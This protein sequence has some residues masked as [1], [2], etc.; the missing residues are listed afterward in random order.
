MHYWTAIAFVILLGYHIP[1]RKLTEHFHLAVT[2]DQLFVPLVIIDSQDRAL[3][4][5]S[6]HKPF[7]FFIRNSVIDEVSVNVVPNRNRVEKVERDETPLILK[8]RDAL[9]FLIGTARLIELTAFAVDKDRI[10]SDLQNGLHH[11]DAGSR[12]V[13]RRRDKPFIGFQ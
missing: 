6:R 5:S 2:V 10:R 7:I 1:A 11:K 3:A 13:M 8:I 4:D 9:N 12:D